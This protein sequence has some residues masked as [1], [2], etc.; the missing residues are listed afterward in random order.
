MHREIRAGLPMARPQ[1]SP[2][3]LLWA[4]GAALALALLVSAPSAAS[5]FDLGGY[6]ARAEATLAELNA[7][8]LADSNATLARLDEMIALGSAGVREYGA[9]HPQYAKLMDAVVADSQAMK[10]MTD[11]ELEEKWGEAGTG[12]DAVG[13]PL[14]SLPEHGQERDY[15]ELVVGP[16]QQYILVKQWQST[17]K[18]RWLEQARD[19][20]VELLKHLEDMRG[21]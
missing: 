19:E 15:I 7:K 17:K 13:V 2:R 20:A 16:A 4:L 12:G 1:G 3:A 10:G 5:A 21:E 6:R 18:A 14:K 8:R 11:V 9:R